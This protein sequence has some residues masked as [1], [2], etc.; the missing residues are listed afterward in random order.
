MAL[1]ASAVTFI[2]WFYRVRVNAERFNPHGHRLKRGWAIGAWFTPV[3]GLWLPRQIA[4][5]T[6]QA[7][8]RPDES[9]IPPITHTLLNLWWGTLW[10]TIVIG[11]LDANFYGQARYPTPTRKRSPG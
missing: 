1:L 6:W 4:A 3:A 5:D 10:A 8:T 11:R 7:S 9:G 2:L